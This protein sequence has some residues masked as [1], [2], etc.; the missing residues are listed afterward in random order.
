MNDLNIV[1]SMLQW[2]SDLLRAH[3][4]YQVFL[5]DNDFDIP[6]YFEK[7]P[8][9]R[10]PQGSH[11]ANHALDGEVQL[12]HSFFSGNVLVAGAN[13]RWLSLYWSDNDPE[14]VYQHRVGIFVQDE[15]RLWEKLLLVAAV[16]FDY[17][18][19]TPF[20]V[21]PR[22][23]LVWRPAPGQALRFHFGRAFRKPSFLNTSTHIKTTEPAP[24]FPEITEF[25]HQS[26]GNEDLHNEEV[27]S[28]ELGYR[29]KF[30]QGALELE[31]D[32]FYNLYRNAILFATH[33]EEDDFGLPDLS[34][35]WFRFENEG[36]DV[37]SVGGSLA[38]HWQA[39]DWLSVRANYT[40]RYSRYTN[41]V[42]NP[43]VEKGDRVYWEPT[44]LFNLGADVR[45][46][47]GLRAGLALFARSSLAD[48]WA[49]DGSL[50][51]ERVRVADPARA[52]LGGY[53]SWRWQQETGWLE[54]GLRV[55]DLL[56]ER[57]RDTTGM[58]T[59]NGKRLGGQWLQR[60]LMFYL[61]GGL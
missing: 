46:Q 7:T 51:G 20:T 9:G 52:M 55:F 11:M 58:T 61:R 6:L 8:L 38:V 19:I 59:S 3:V 26:I 30:F 37:D 16:R 4:W 17:N 22:A 45:F 2:R 25:V 43:Y 32:A 54:A 33:L 24:G 50:F 13:Y 21:S 29:G 42:P 1:R 31:A 47:S 14:A 40:Y 53:L 57:W 5:V 36:L 23:A 10:V 41:Q 56:N 18:S 12:T 35:S 49:Q 15:Q 44:Q 60:L 48:F 27:T 28:F 39:S 34:R